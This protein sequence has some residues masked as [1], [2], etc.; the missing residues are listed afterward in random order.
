MKSC[1]SSRMSAYSMRPRMQ[2][3]LTF[4]KEVAD[5]EMKF[6]VVKAAET[7]DVFSQ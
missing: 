2:M 3:Q 1:G 4:R 6:L 7:R 5:G